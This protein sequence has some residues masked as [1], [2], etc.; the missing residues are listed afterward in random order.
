MRIPNPDRGSVLIVAA[1]LSVLLAIAL[2]SYLQLSQS[3][4]KLANRSFYSYAAMDLADTGLEQALWS[5][6]NNNW[7]GGGF[8][9]AA[10]S[11]AHWQGTFPSATSSFPLSQSVQGQVK[12]WVDQNTP[13]YPHAV[14]LATVTLG[15]GTT[16]IKEAEVYIHKRSYFA[17]GLVAKQ[18]ITFVGNNAS[19]DSWNSDP[20][21]D[22]STA[23]VP[24]SSSV[25]HDNGQVGS[26]SVAVDTIIVSNADIYGF[27]AVGGSSLS[28]ISV[29]ANGLVGPY[30][31]TNGTIDTTHVTYDFTTSF[32]EVAAPSTSG[33]SIAAISGSITL[34]RTGDV[35]ASDGCYYYYTPNITLGGSG[36]TLS[37]SGSG[38]K[39]VIVLG[40]P[41][42]T[43]KTVAV[44]G[45]GGI[46][47]TTGSS[48][49]MYT[50]GDVEI[51]GNGVANGTT[52]SPNQPTGFQLYGT[53]TAAFAATSGIG[54]QDIKIAGNGVLSGVVYAPNANAEFNGGGTNGKVMGAMV[55]NQI[56]VTG[57]SAFHYDESLVNFGSSNLWK[58]TK[59]R[60]LTSAADRAVYASHF[61]F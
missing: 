10:T 32:P 49:S 57:G 39:V 55:A 26:T 25:A 31:T 4:L 13:S 59:W 50:S 17:N 3:S 29:G 53:R 60:E 46:S 48:L 27:A 52:A 23:A 9:Q 37:I 5:L 43:N 36:D 47:I 15:D 35:A 22:P 19:V 54:M 40:P 1:I 12:V 51:A 34:P 61:N 18:T 6:N 8:V 16:L 20:D 30:G 21:G 14:A 11:A 2:G 7:T 41:N 45:N 58:L 56:R 42:T 38:A 33:Y 44:T 28:G 24:Y